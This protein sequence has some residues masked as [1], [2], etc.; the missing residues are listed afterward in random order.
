[1]LTNFHVYNISI[2]MKW[3]AWTVLEWSWPVVSTIDLTDLQS[4]TLDALYA[5]PLQLDHN[6]LDV[7]L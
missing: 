5:Y 6:L 4:V 3:I 2:E 7:W 1:M